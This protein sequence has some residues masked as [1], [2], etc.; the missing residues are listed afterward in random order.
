MWWCRSTPAASLSVEGLP[1]LDQVLRSFPSTSQGNHLGSPEPLDIRPNGPN[2]LT[3]IPK[4]GRRTA[5]SPRKHAIRDDWAARRN[6]R[7]CGGFSRLRLRDRDSNPNFRTHPHGYRPFPA[8]ARCRTDARFRLRRVPVSRPYFDKLATRG[9]QCARF[10]ARSEL[11]VPRVAGV[12]GTARSA[13]EAVL[14]PL[15]LPACGQAN[16]AGV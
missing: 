9:Q 13:A 11:R 15:R 3:S 14:C 2:R 7:G 1:V 8:I 4:F 5:R 16:T 10:F 6:P 12:G